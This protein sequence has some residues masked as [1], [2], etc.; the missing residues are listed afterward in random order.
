MPTLK[1]VV[2]G[3]SLFL[4]KV[5]LKAQIESESEGNFSS[6]LPPW[7]GS[8]NLSLNFLLQGHFIVISMLFKRN[9]AG[10]HNNKMEH[11]FHIV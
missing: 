6:E 8:R 5:C 7:N 2:D 4:L 1:Y 3:E 10:Y 9:S 11:T